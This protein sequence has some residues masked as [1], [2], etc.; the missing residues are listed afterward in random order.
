MDILVLQTM[1]L[2]ES[3]IGG[4]MKAMGPNYMCANKQMQ[5][6]I[7]KQKDLTP[8]MLSL[9]YQERRLWYQLKNT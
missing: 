2:E 7:S 1:M 9:K 3:N 4:V 8:R 6:K 5:M